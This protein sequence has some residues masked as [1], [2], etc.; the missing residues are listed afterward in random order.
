MPM[1]RGVKET[2]TGDGK[3]VFVDAG[4]TADVFEKR[5]IEFDGAESANE[6]GTNTY[7]YMLNLSPDERKAFLG[8]L[9][10][11]LCKAIDKEAP[12][13]SEKLL[14][15][16]EDSVLP[17]DDQLLGYLSTIAGGPQ[18][19]D[20]IDVEGTKYSIAFVPQRFGD[21][22]DEYVYG[23]LKFN[24]YPDDVIEKVINNAGVTNM[25]IMEWIGNHEGAH[26]NGQSLNGNAAHDT[27]REEV[28]ADSISESQALSE[29][30]EH[31]AQFFL[32]FRA[33]TYIDTPHATAVPLM[34]D[35][36]VSYVHSQVESEFY[37]TMMNNVKANFDFDKYQGQA[38]NANDLL[39]ENPDAFFE[40]LDKSLAER[41]EYTADAYKQNPDDYNTLK[42]TLATQIYVDRANAFK[43]AYKR[44]VMGEK[45]T[46]DAQPTQILSDKSERQIYHELDL[47]EDIQNI[48]AIDRS[49]AISAFH[50]DRHYDPAVHGEGPKDELAANKQYLEDLRRDAA[51]RLADNPNDPV[52]LEHAIKV[53]YAYEYHAFRYNDMLTDHLPVHQDEFM[54]YEPIVPDD[55]KRL[56]YRE[57][58]VELRAK[59]AAEVEA[60]EAEN[61]KHEAEEDQPIKPEEQSP[62]KPEAEAP[63]EDTQIYVAKVPEYEGDTAVKVDWENPENTTAIK[64]QYNHAANPP[65][66]EVIDPKVAQEVNEIVAK[67]EMDVRQDEVSHST[68]GM[69]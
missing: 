22:V 53:D 18:A 5:G 40:A 9:H 48:A 51:Q 24:N 58:A 7:N 50:P 2:H 69:G 14:T 41:V 8:E 65:S 67:A 43:T 23:A 49:E 66:H 35:D 52:A 26:L 31:V 32:D 37:F 47:D 15:K 1:S 62:A 45:D 20:N 4:D 28:R 11:S 63:L 12:G 19:A 33:L 57:Q 59:V 29:G 16:P 64:D 61:Q 17:W 36:P 55:Q 3:L 60:Q 46:P 39:H 44:L 6:L 56:H 34:T 42:S 10:E 21:E 25:E 38:K 13:A 30:K 27:L 68:M 54:K